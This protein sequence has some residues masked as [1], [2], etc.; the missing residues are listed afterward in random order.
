MTPQRTIR[1]FPVGGFVSIVSRPS[2]PVG[3]YAGH[4]H[5]HQ[6]LCNRVGGGDGAPSLVGVHGA[7]EEIGYGA[8]QARAHKLQ[9]LLCIPGVRLG[10][11]LEGGGCG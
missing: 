9:G 3:G 11:E 1:P 10:I 7:S 2:Y 4:H 8:S 6:T 5:N